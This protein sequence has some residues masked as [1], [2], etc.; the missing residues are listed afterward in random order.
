MLWVSL[1]LMGIAALALGAVVV[2]WLIVGTS[3]VLFPAY[4][5]LRDR[6]DP[7]SPANLERS[8]TREDA[9]ELKDQ[10]AALYAATQRDPDRW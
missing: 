9:R 5:A 1:V 6:L 4:E 3:T 10:M 2:E 8:L 7:A